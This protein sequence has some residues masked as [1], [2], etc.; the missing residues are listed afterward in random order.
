MF[1]TP[2]R[3]K[4]TFLSRMRT[5][6]RPVAEAAEQDQGGSSSAEGRGATASQPPTA[7][8][9]DQS[10]A[11]AGV[12]AGALPSGPG[13]AGWSARALWEDVMGGGSSG[14]AAGPILDVDSSP[15]GFRSWDP[16]LDGT[17][18]PGCAVSGQDADGCESRGGGLEAV[19]T[20]M[21]DEGRSWRGRCTWAA[22]GPVAEAMDND[23]TPNRGPGSKTSTTTP[24]PTPRQTPLQQQQQQQAPG[25]RVAQLQ[26]VALGTRNN[27]ATFSGSAF[28]PRM[29][30][31][32][33][34][35]PSSSGV[36]GWSGGGSASGVGGFGGSGRLA[37]M[38][39]AAGGFG[40]RPIVRSSTQVLD[41]DPGKVDF[42]SVGLLPSMTLA[43]TAPWMPKVAPVSRL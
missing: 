3:P 17:W 24:Q 22:A 8:H 40:G 18:T 6:L 29:N 19:A 23:P 30:A 34:M 11:G 25:S 14:A 27:L 36:G 39:M 33:N 15:D 20:G 43:S 1:E 4:G 13:A 21:S 26:E 41:M 16:D 12:V 9:L 28:I 38:A 7:S 42:V 2:P 32:F 37:P 31:T 35:P 5:A 10:A